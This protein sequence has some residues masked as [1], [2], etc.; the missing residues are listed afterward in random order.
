VVDKYS[1]LRQAAENDFETFIRLIQPNR[2]LGAVHSEAI[3]WVT[4]GEG[5]LKSH[6]LILLP[7]DHQKSTIFG[8]LL[9]AWEITRNPA[10]K[11]LYISSTSNI[12]VQQLKF[13]KDILTSDLYRLFWPDMVNIDEAKREKWAE[14]AISV[15][16]PSRREQYVRDPTVFAA[17]LTT[18]VTGMHPDLIIGDDLV[19][20]DNANTEEARSKVSMQYSF[21][22][23]VE[24]AKGRQVLV[25]TRYDPNDLYNNIMNMKVTLR[26]DN[27]N[28]KSEE[29]LFSIF[30]RQVE[31]R[32]DGTGEFLWPR[33]K[34]A[35]GMEFGFN[36]EILAGK[37]ALYQGNEVQ[38]Y[39][40][41]Y[42]NP[43]IGDE[44]S[45]SRDTF[46]YY[47]RSFL[48]ND[49]GNWFYN[50]RRLNLFAAMDLA[51]TTGSRSDYTSI[52]VIGVD[53]YN[54]IYVL[55]IV[56][57]KTGD[58]SVYYNELL[59][60][61]NKWGFWQIVIEATAGQEYIAND[62]K[63]NYIRPN[64][65]G[66][67]TKLF[68]P[69]RQLGNKEERIHTVLKPRYDNGQIWHYM[70]GNCQIL[71]DEL[72]QRK[73]PHDD[74]K[75]TLATAILNAIAPIDMRMHNMNPTQFN[76]Y[77]HRRFGGMA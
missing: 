12:A 11:I 73:P 75:D 40:Q 76:D 16:H 55:D 3:H 44:N 27:G 68:K 42:N 35:N 48:R 14:T 17:G 51:Y 25:G 59:K 15:D 7:R 24:T 56:R 41:Y 13:I 32:G 62:L 4:K 64:G 52:V 8:G 36:A 37:K 65:L 66:L 71:E 2:L 31:N 18:S 46:Q 58:P 54:S 20:Y 72:V 19:V 22:A 39:A 21:L 30:E 23:S 34:A 28:V 5:S 6:V 49:G 1:A 26:D 74:V 67:T 33:Q 63:I 60:L 29:P 53:M 47:D 69:T 70:G 38:F 50:G 43:N 10:I 61:H 9:A 45:I 57:F 77:T